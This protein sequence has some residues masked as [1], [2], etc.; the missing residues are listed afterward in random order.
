MSHEIARSIAHHTLYAPSTTLKDI[1]PSLT[2]GW[3]GTRK[4]ADK[5]LSAIG[6]EL[7]NLQERLFAR[8]R[9]GDPR[10]ILLILQGMDSSGKGGIVRHVIGAVDPQG[11]AH[12]SFGKPTPEELQHDFLWRITKALPHPGFI[13]VFDRSHY[14]D[15]LVARVNDLAPDAEIERRYNAINNF[16]HEL[17]TSGVTVIKVLLH[18]SR[19]EQR[20]RLEDRL[21][22]P[23]KYWKYHPSDVDERLK[24]PAYEEAFPSHA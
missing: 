24:W 4:K 15:V 9:H 3:S 21:N 5:E 7:S 14:E 1:D 2:P 17:T 16:E 8:G 19:D 10:S 23:D 20:A 22:R 11:V 6:K 18:I 12:Q 13:G